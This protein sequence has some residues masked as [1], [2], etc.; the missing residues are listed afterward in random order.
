MVMVNPNTLNAVDRMRFFK[1]MNCM[2]NV[3]AELVESGVYCE[4][5]GVDVDGDGCM[6]ISYTVAVPCF[7][8]E[9]QTFVNDS[10]CVSLSVER[11]SDIMYHDEW[12]ENKFVPFMCET[13]GL[14]YFSTAR[15]VVIEILEHYTVGGKFKTLG[16]APTNGHLAAFKKY[17][18]ISAQPTSYVVKHQNIYV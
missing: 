15:E 13:Y 12:K 10:M 8:E 5:F 14:G 1:A 9:K 7:D 16:C 17:D 18:L 4:P 11:F 6:Q 3:V 2:Q